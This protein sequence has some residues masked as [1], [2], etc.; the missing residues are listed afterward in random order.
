M[1]TQQ[2]IYTPFGSHRNGFQ[3]FRCEHLWIFHFIRCVCRC[4]CAQCVWRGGTERGGEGARL[5]TYPFGIGE[6][7]MAL[8]SYRK[9]LRNVHTRAGVRWAGRRIVA[10]R[11]WNE[12]NL[13]RKTVHLQVNLNF[14]EWQWDNSNVNGTIETTWK[15]TRRSAHSQMK[16]QKRE[17]GSRDAIQMTRTIVTSFLYRFRFWLWI[18]LQHGFCAICWIAC[19]DDE[20]SFFSVRSGLF[21]EC[22]LRNK[23]KMVFIVE[24]CNQM[25]IVIMSFIG[26]CFWIVFP[27]KWCF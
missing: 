18:R 16:K 10:P 6:Y 7:A 12:C 26:F 17:A 8:E 21:L 19:I 14:H 11:H 4:Q 24:L 3:R 5:S 9:R 25:L 15:E 23:W 27:F 1:Q 20:H 13:F 2:P 22:S